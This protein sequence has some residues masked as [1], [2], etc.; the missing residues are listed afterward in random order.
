MFQ[1]ENFDIKLDTDF[2][3]RQF[4]YIEEVE[5]T[6]LLLNKNSSQFNKNGTVLLAE[7][8]TKGKGRNNR[9]WASAK[10]LNLT[11]SILLTDP[12]ILKSNP[13]IINLSASLAVAT[14][15]ENKFQ[16]NTNLKW[17]N[18]VLIKDKKVSGILCE[19]STK[20]KKIDR[21][22]VGIGINVNQVTFP[23]DYKLPASSI[24]NEFKSA[25]ERESLLAEVLNLFEYF[26]M[27][28]IIDKDYILKEWRLKCKMIGD[29]ITID[30]GSN[31]KTGIFDDIDENGFLIL[32]TKSGLERIVS[33][34]VSII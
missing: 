7:S 8:Q 9:I 10:D 4:Y 1:L 16:L 26:L 20:G 24:K 25:V 5:S 15:I 27:K 13:N 12:D 29:K 33:G 30:D 3:G 19:S 22:I 11:F 31:L 28:S 34:D 6:N 14:A 21:I 17:P 18:D 23:T 32:K 2:I